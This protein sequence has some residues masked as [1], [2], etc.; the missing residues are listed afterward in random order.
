M[1]RVPEKDWLDRD[2]PDVMCEDREECRKRYDEIT[3]EEGW[4]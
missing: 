1:I 3:R 2:I 4:L